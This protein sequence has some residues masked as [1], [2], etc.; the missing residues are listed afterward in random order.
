MAHVTAVCGNLKDKIKKSGAVT[1]TANVISFFD[2]GE[3]FL[4]VV[5]S[6]IF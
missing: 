5:N 1:W 4:R 2:V 3:V 6:Q